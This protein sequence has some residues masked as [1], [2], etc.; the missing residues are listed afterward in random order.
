[1]E[2]TFWNAVHLL[3]F[4]LGDAGF[5]F[6]KNTHIQM[7]DAKRFRQENENSI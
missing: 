6:Y 7:I 1:M 4:R 5:Y 3:L 2:K